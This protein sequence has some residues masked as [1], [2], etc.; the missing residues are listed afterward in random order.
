[1]PQSSS[2]ENSKQRPAL[3]SRQW[4]LRRQ[5]QILAAAF[6]QFAAKGYAE[7]RLEDVAERAGIA[8]GT[9][10]LYFKNKELLFR[11]VFRGLIHHVFEELEDFVQTFPGSTEELVRRVFSQ[12][13]SEIVGNPKARAMLRLL[14]AE[15]HRFPQLSDVYL[16]EVITPG[17]AAMRKLVEKGVSSGEFR[18]TKIAEFPQ[19]LIGPAVLAVVWMLILGERRPLDLDD[20]MN[21]HLEFALSGLRKQSPATEQNC[22][23]VSS[24][25]GLQ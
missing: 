8:K 23:K 21:A 14:I 20:F 3:H 18:E 5:E 25:G 17:M 9:I 24:Q 6:E 13:Y 4:K 16:H 11:A 7:A 2:Q 15:S 10:Y 22:Q 1:M 19:I 12:L